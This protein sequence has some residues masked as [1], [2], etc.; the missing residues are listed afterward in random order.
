MEL[1]LNK[2]YIPIDV[3]I[4]L[5]K[6]GEWVTTTDNRHLLFSENYGFFKNIKNMNLK[7]GWFKGKVIKK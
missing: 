7:T 4:E 1:K 2:V 3:K 5:P 6:N